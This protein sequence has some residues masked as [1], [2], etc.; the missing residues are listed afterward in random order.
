MALSNSLAEI[1]R[2]AA[3]VK[4][5]GV[6]ALALMLDGCDNCGDWFG[7]PKSQAGSLDA[8]HKQAPPPRGPS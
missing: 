5:I 2:S 6:L 4:L 1:F 7:I 8:C 3:A